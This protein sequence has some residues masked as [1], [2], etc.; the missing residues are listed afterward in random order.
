MVVAQEDMYSRLKDYN[1]VFNGA[2]YDLYSVVEIDE[3]GAL[4]FQIGKIVFTL[5]RFM[6]KGPA[7]KINALGESAKE[8]VQFTFIGTRIPAM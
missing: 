7:A 3:K 8:V 2:E 1:W 5:D 6:I 4:T